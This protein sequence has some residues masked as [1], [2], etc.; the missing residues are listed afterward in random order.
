MAC[1]NG[2]PG[3]MAAPIGVPAVGP[4][5]GAQ[6]GAMSDQALKHQH[7]V[8]HL[9]CR[10]AV[11]PQGIDPYNTAVWGARRDVM[12]R[13]PCPE[14]AAPPTT[15]TLPRLQ[16]GVGPGA[17][18]GAMMPMGGQGYGMQPGMMQQ[19]MMMPQ[20]GMGGMGPCAGLGGYG[21]GAVPNGQGWVSGAGNSG[22]TSTVTYV[23]WGG[24]FS[25]SPEYDAKGSPHGFYGPASI[26]ALMNNNNP[27]QMGGFGAQPQGMMPG[28]MM[29]AMGGMGGACCVPG[30]GGYGVPNH[31]GNA[32]PTAEGGR[33][34]AFAPDV[35][36]DDYYQRRERELRGGYVTTVEKPVAESRTARPTS[37]SPVDRLRR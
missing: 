28:G 14:T 34:R 23:D 30:G 13:C 19:G 11:C 3:V 8:N 10:E 16:P 1:C 4:M 9:A 27:C 17:G 33:G 12:E 2:P 26:G 25:A 29:G 22:N 37:H 18:A 36:H 24:R 5:P 15:N 31:F 20:Q 35:S 6:S 21:P 7:V 32:Y